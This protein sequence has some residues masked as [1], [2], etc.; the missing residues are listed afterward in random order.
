MSI[1]SIILLYTYLIW[2]IWYCVYFGKRSVQ[3]DYFGNNG[4]QLIKVKR[5]NVGQ[6]VG[7]PPLRSY[8]E[9]TEQIVAN[10]GDSSDRDC[11]SQIL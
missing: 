9:I 10:I 4:L 11:S 5:A 7:R 2:Y 3:C 8:I 1:Q 6:A